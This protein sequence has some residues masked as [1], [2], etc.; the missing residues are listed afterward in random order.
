M[1]RPPFNHPPSF[2]RQIFHPGHASGND[3]SCCSWTNYSEYFHAPNLN[4]WGTTTTGGAT[5]GAAWMSVSPA[6]EAANA[7]PDNQTANHAVSTLEA[8]ESAAAAGTLTKPFF[9]AVGF[10]KPH[11]PFVAS[12]EF[13]DYYPPSSV[14]LPPDQQP[15][16]GMFVR[17]L[18]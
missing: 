5:N 6:L 12:E 9:L 8:L 16:A 2:T 17:F 7:L 10:H 1:H 4:F 11:L 18:L 13:F 14:Q 15:P 3:D